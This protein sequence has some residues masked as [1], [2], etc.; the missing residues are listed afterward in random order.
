MHDASLNGSSL[1]K[2]G[3]RL[4]TLA[5]FRCAH[6]S[7]ACRAMMRT[8][9]KLLEEA[10]SGVALASQPRIVDDESAMELEGYPFIMN[11][12]SV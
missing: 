3:E 9:G 10:C 5:L 11:L 1:A 4:H 7:Q 6:W 2:R 8:R 12:D